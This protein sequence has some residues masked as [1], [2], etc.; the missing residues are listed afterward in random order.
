MEKMRKRIGLNKG[1][2]KE[3]E[4][5]KLISSTIRHSFSEILSTL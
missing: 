1:V 4:Q 3:A 5:E 2:K